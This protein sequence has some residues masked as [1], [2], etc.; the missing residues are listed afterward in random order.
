VVGL[1]ENAFK[2]DE[3]AIAMGKCFE[4]KFF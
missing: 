3:K 2:I 4:F 1:Q